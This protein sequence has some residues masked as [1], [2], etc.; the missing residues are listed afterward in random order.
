MVEMPSERRSRP[1]VEN[2][3]RE[4]ADEFAF[5]LELRTRELIEEGLSPTEAR[6]EARRGF[7]DMAEVEARCRRLAA[8]R[9][10]ARRR[11]RWFGDVRR[12]LVFGVRQLRRTPVLTAAVVATLAL[13]IGGVT[14]LFSVVD[15]TLLRPLPFAGGERIVVIYETWRGFDRGRASPG[16]FLT[17]ATEAGTLEA[18]AAYDEASFNLDHGGDPERLLGAEVTPSYFQ[19]LDAPP[20]AGRYFTEDEG[21]WPAAQV[22]VLGWTTWQAR[23]GGDRDV[24]GSTIRLNQ[25]TYTVVGVTPREFTQV[26]GQD[27]LF[28]PA[29]FEPS[30]AENFGS[31]GLRLL[32]RHRSDA[33]LDAVRAELERLTL[34]IAERAPQAMADRGVHAAPLSAELV[35]NTRALVLAMFAAVAFVLVMAVVNVASLLLARSAARRS[36]VAVRVAL[37]GSRRR[38]VGQL[39]TESLLL[40][41]IGGAAGLAVAHAGVGALRGLAVAQGVP[42]LAAVTLNGPAVLFAVALTV[43]AGLAFGLAPALR[44]TRNLQGALREGGRGGTPG[45]DRVRSGLVVVEVA[46]ALTLLVASALLVRSSA[47]LSNVPPGF[48]ADDVMTAHVSLP[49]AGYESPEAVNAAFGTMLEHL[50][51]AP[52]V[53]SAALLSHIPLTGVGFDSGIYPEPIDYDLST[54]PSPHQ[55]AVSPGF[56]DTFGMELKAG[57]ALTESDLRAQAPHVVLVNEELARRLTAFDPAFQPVVGRRIAAWEGSPDVV[58]WREIVGVVGDTR[59]QGAA[60]PPVP[61]LFFPYTRVPS[62]YWSTVQRTVGLAVRA[63]GNPLDQVATLRA[64][65]AEVDPGLPLY[66]VEPMAAVVRRASATRRLTVTLFALFGGVA[67]VLAVVGIY[68][69]VAFVVGERR[70]EFG[71]R[72]ALGATGGD[73]VRLVLR[74]GARLTVLGLVAGTLGA[75][76]AGRLLTSLLEG[77]APTDPVAW[78]AGAGLLTAAALA[79]SAVPAVRALRVPPTQALRE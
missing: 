20:A 78:A 21:E 62:W 50:E 16:H 70:R 2:A 76:G 22:A 4:V 40:A 68:G 24:V 34:G 18:V 25:Q 52:G 15:A 9:D 28:V 73:V 63:E 60:E 14:A 38:I 66:S 13:G 79:A 53:R 57:R 5:H 10:G 43:L 8:K 6:A 23:F 65:V 55:R 64:A 32:A 54:I 3:R 45:R 47:R 49:A 37:G 41:V 27:Q 35:R 31:H 56:L 69:V 42:R 58:V 44:S 30:E 61:E 12:D 29:A 33:T 1:P 19:V 51:A 46:C 17:Y 67:L 71:V 39:L 48:V 77:V 7:G 72:Q 11:R 36:E 26:P 74:Q 59:S 75:W